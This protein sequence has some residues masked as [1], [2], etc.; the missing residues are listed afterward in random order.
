MKLLD[1]TGALPERVSTAGATG[2]DVKIGAG[3]VRSRRN[4][5]VDGSPS[6]Q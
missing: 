6:R 4:R 1:S 5:H 3:Q 2:T